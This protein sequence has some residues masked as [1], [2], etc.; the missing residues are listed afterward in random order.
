MVSFIDTLF[1]PDIPFLR[2]ALFAG[3]LSSIPFGIIGSLVVVKRMTYIAGSVS[4]AVLGGIGIAVFLKTSLKISLITPM[5]GALIFAIIIGIIISITTIYGNER[6]DTVIGTIW[7][8]GMGIGLLFFHITPEYTDPMSYLFGNILYITQSDINI[9]LVLNSIIILLS[10][11]FYNQLVI[12]AFDKEFAQIRGLNTTVYQI[13]LIILISMTVL[14]LVTII[15]IVMVIAFLTI[16]PAIAGIFT[17]K[18][19]NM[20][21]T[22]ILLCAVFMVTGLYFSSVLNLP[23]SS[24]TIVITGFIYFSILIISKII[25]TKQGI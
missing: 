4:H 10:V 7:A 23:T 11:T 1:N 20:M 14:L 17:K 2:Y 22:S 24:I 6:M 18:I 12:V 19:K 3:L 25:K 16:P 8:M 9:I 5:L 13:M 21:I 15:G